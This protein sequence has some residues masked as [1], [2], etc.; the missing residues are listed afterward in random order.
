MIYL[1]YRYFYRYLK[2]ERIRKDIKMLEQKWTLVCR[3]TINYVR[4]ECFM[5]YNPGSK[6]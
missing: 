2:R 3:L 4:R 1:D 6:Y 5:I